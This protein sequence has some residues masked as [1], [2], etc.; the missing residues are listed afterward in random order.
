[1]V[2][3]VGSFLASLIGMGAVVAYG[4]RRPPGTPLSWGEAMVAATFAFGLMFWVYGV[5]P[6]QW[7]Q[8]ANNELGWTPTKKLNGPW[9]VLVNVKAINTIA[10]N[11]E[12]IRDLI[13]V[14]I[15]G[16]YLAAHVGMWVVWNNRGTKAEAKAQR[17]LA[18]STYGRP[19]VKQG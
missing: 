1:V 4:K 17:E 16:F 7:L 6:H 2:A 15:Y 3:F 9:N 11:Y 13:V 8:W 19:L 12:H 10:V 14:G 5:V 18:P